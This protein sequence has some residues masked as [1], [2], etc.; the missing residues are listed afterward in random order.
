MRSLILQ[1][2][3]Q[4]EHKWL[5][6]IRRFFRGVSPSR[7]FLLAPHEHLRMAHLYLRLLA[8]KAVGVLRF[9]PTRTSRSAKAQATLHDLE[10][11]VYCP[12]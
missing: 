12:Q 11:C 6:R 2:H 9:H 7:R 5:R 3:L 4:T 10:H 1:T 8:G